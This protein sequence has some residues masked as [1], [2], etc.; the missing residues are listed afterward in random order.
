MEENAIYKGIKDIIN[1]FLIIIL[2]I[3][4][5]IILQLILIKDISSHNFS[6]VNLS[7]IF[8]ELIL[9]IV[10]I[11][12]FRKKLVPDFY[13]F[14]KN[15][16]NYIKNNWQYWLYGLIIMLI[17]NAIISSF[18]GLP[19]NEESVRN[20]LTK[21]PIYSIISTIICGPIIEELMTRTIL[22]DTF[23]NHYIYYIL[24]GLIFGSLHLLS[25]TNINEIF[26]I[27]SY[28]TLGYFFALIYDKTNNIWTNIFFHSLHNTLAILIVFLSYLVGV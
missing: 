8:I 21:I 12:I 2:Y 17:L 6:L 5:S 22:K 24:S 10:F 7:Y 23:K 28:G 13:D 9:L 25:A 27:F 19:T 18:I 20:L 14:K 11:L 3:F 26:Y 16:K 1:Q 4:L 15:G